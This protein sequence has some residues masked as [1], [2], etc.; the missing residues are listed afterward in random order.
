MSSDQWEFAFKQNA[1]DIIKGVD[2]NKTIARVEPVEE[3]S[4]VKFEIEDAHTYISG[5]LISHN[6]KNSGDYWSWINEA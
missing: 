2:G 6:V 1:G 3:G 4:V 5:S